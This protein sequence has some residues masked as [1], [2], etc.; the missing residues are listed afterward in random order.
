MSS[1]RSRRPGPLAGMVLAV[2]ASVSACG[3][4]DEPAEPPPSTVGP[5]TEIVESTGL[6]L[7]PASGYGAVGLL[8][9]VEGPESC[10]GWQGSVVG[11]DT[12]ASVTIALWG[13]GCVSTEGLNGQRVQYR[14]VSDVLSGEVGETREVAVGTA[15][16][17]DD[18]YVECTNECDEYE[19]RI[20]LVELAQPTDP[21]F[22]SVMIST[23]DDVSFDDLLAIAG[24]LRVGAAG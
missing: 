14:S 16:V 12:G 15:T 3:D 7:D 9:P 19:D 18:L 24:A 6:T 13:E 23:I 17:I 1:A 22:P 2:L 10:R 8:E 4:D 21:A 11:D 20:V 5:G